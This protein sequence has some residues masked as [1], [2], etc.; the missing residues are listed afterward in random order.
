MIAHRNIDEESNP[1]CPVVFCVSTRAPATSKSSFE[2]WISSEKVRRKHIICPAYKVITSDNSELICVRELCGH[3]PLVRVIED[4]FDNVRQGHNVRI[5]QVMVKTAAD[6]SM[7][8]ASSSASSSNSM[9]PLFGMYVSKVKPL[10]CLQKPS[11]TFLNRCAAATDVVASSNAEKPTKSK[12]IANPDGLSGGRMEQEQNEHAQDQI[13]GLN[14]LAEEAEANNVDR[15]ESDTDLD[16]DDDGN[17][18]EFYH[19]VSRGL[20]AAYHPTVFNDDE[21]IEARTTSMMSNTTQEHLAE[22]H[23]RAVAIEAVK[24]NVCNL[25]DGV[26]QQS[27]EQMRRGSG[28]DAVDAAVET[29]VATASGLPPEVD[30][31]DEGHQFPKFVLF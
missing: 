9:E 25:D 3:R 24:N 28:M 10:V 7:C 8:L 21:V 22:S 27:I 30:L 20:A 31:D 17:E 14:L 29:C 26:V 5:C 23:D 18:T 1:L 4:Q 2:F 16:G 15:D 12:H 6:C 13:L 11:A 19:F